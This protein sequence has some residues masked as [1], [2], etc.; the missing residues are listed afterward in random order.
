MALSAVGAALGSQYGPL[1]IHGG[2]TGLA[3][4]RGAIAPDRARQLQEEVLE[5]YQVRREAAQ[6]QARGEFTPTEREGLRMAAQP[7]LQRVAGSIASRG[8]GSSPAGAAI[9]AQAEQA[10]FSTAQQRA[11]QTEQIINRDAFNAAT[12]LAN[13][14]SSFYEDLQGIAR[15]LQTIRGLKER[16]DQRAMDTLGSAFGMREGYLFYDPVSAIGGEV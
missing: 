8:L 6:R 13:R 14:D 10:V 12:S 9:A 7:A 11:A 2:L 5:G 3:A 4:L 1:L 15:A 16:P